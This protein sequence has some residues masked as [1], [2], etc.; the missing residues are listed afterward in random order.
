MKTL[1]KKL[2]MVCTVI[3]FSI[4]TQ[5]VL[6]SGEQ[7]TKRSQIY[8]VTSGWEADTVA[9]QLVTDSSSGIY[10]NPAGCAYPQAGYVADP[11]DPGRKLYQDQIREAF[12]YQQPVKF[13]ISA[14]ACSYGKPRMIGVVYCRAATGLGC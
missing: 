12:L 6:A 14:T 1:N 10:T 9:V 7:W 11:Q 8:T 5:A 4:S 13:L 2:F 3:G